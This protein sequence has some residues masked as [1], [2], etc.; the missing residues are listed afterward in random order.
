MARLALSFDG[1]TVPADIKCP[2]ELLHVLAAFGV[3]AGPAGS[4]GQPSINVQ[5]A[6]GKFHFSGPAYLSPFGVTGVDAAAGSVMAG[7]AACRSLAVDA[8]T[9]C[10]H[11]AAARI[12][13][14]TYLFLAPF[15]TGKSS[16][17]AELAL[18]G[19]EILADDVVLVNVRE[20][21]IA[22]LPIPMRLREGFVQ[23]SRVAMTAWIGERRIFAGPRYTYLTPRALAPGRH[24]L[25]DII[26][27][28]RA[29]RGGQET[30]L[31]TA[32]P[33]AV[34]PRILWHNMSRHHAP[35][36]I[37]GMAA[38]LAAT[39]R[40]GILQVADA[41]DAAGQLFHGTLSAVEGKGEAQI[42]SMQRDALLITRTDRGAII[43]NDE[44]GRIFEINE[45][46]FVILTL[47][48]Q[49]DDDRAM[50]DMLCTVYPDAPRTELARQ[51]R[52]CLRQF[53][54][55][56]LV[57]VSRAQSFNTGHEPAPC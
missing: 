40:G 12:Q 8:D 50:W 15:G 53:A 4:S 27:L 46:A 23:G 18:L 5:L 42:E 13:D 19:A 6:E 36:A 14:R 30:V 52:K 11:G 33:G 41:A 37:A 35:S 9:L 22:G 28:G 7:L 56:G 39:L 38:S 1:L 43:S 34:I 3:A 20:L 47:L 49:V 55:C 26:L 54:D 31:E 16:L 29:P 32:S 2:P 48:Q 51:V 57:G 17:M 44:T 45:S 24:P 21:T 25:T 10:I